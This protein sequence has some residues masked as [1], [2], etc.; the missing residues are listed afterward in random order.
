MPPFYRQVIERCVKIKSFIQEEPTTINQLLNQLIWH[1]TYLFTKIRHR[2]RSIFVSNWIKSGI[3]Y[4]KYLD[5][6]EGH[7]SESYIIK[8][9][10]NKSSFLI[11]M[12]EIKEALRPYKPYI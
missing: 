10:K 4:V 6:S 5:D 9:L 2:K 11:E 1:N 8:H 7:V 12:K 3:L